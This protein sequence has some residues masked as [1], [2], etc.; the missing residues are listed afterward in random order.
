MGPCL[1]R[2]AVDNPTG[3]PQR[4][5]LVIGIRTERSLLPK[6]PSAFRSRSSSVSGG[7]K[8]FPARFYLRGAA[9]SQLWSPGQLAGPILSTEAAPPPRSFASIRATS[10]S[11][12]SV[13]GPGAGK[14]TF[15]LP[16]PTQNNAW[17]WTP[18][19]L[20]IQGHNYLSALYQPRRR[21]GGRIAFSL[22]HVGDFIQRMWP[23]T[24]RRSR[25]GY[26]PKRFRPL[27]GLTLSVPPTAG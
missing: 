6:W 24:S 8:P 17:R 26:F 27:R 4:H 10:V 3:Q 19:F 9:L 5:A 13:G 11:Q 20:R 23:P 14:S 21:F 7:L 22:F 25:E 2:N 12:M 18:F 1:G 15:R 16:A